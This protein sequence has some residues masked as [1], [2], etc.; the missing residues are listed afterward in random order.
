MNIIQKA[1]MRACTQYTLS[2]II[3][4]LQLN[5]VHNSMVIYQT[6]SV[7]IFKKYQPHTL[8]NNAV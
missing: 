1:S 8:S 4:P 7:A 6:Y 2:S 5:H 3:Q